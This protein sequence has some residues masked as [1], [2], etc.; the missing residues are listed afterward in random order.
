MNTAARRSTLGLLILLG[1][2]H[3]SDALSQTRAA[4]PQVVTRIGIIGCHQQPHP[5]PALTRYVAMKPQVVLWVGDNVYADTKDDPSH[6]ERCYSVLEEKPGFREL[7]DN[8][9][10]LAVWDD[11]DYGMNNDGKN[12]PLKHQSKEIFRKFW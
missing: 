4:E 11:H 1:L 2:P 9:V 6:I 10:F 7:R 3:C 8:S 12:Y 5:A